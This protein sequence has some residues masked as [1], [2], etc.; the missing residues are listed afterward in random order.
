MRKLWLLFIFVSVLFFSLQVMADMKKENQG[1]KY[2]MPE[3]K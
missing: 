3:L 1:R 2:T